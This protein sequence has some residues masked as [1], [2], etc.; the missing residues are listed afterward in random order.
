MG[1]RGDE[2]GDAEDGDEKYPG[3]LRWVW[4]VVVAPKLGEATDAAD[5]PEECDPRE[6]SYA[7]STMSAKSCKGRHWGR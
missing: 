2:L 1:G 4:L 6:G 5:A 7:T 3:A